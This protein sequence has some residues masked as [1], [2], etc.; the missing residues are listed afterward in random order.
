MGNCYMF[1]SV[2]FLLEEVTS[3]M[4]KKSIFSETELGEKSITMEIATKETIYW[5]Y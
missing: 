4:Y 5:M 2:I 1:P 3:G